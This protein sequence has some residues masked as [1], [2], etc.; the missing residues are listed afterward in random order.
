MKRFLLLTGL[1][2]I[3]FVPCSRADTITDRD[4]I[5][6]QLVLKG[7]Q[8]TCGAGDKTF[9]IEMKEVRV[10]LSDDIQTEAW[11]FN[12]TVPGPVLEA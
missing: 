6:A 3:I 8:P 12:G 1:M 10:Q 9:E 7:Q 5:P 11:T 2:A 4:T